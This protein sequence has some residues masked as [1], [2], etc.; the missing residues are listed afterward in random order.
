MLWHTIIR[1]VHFPQMD[2]ITCTQ[3]RLQQIDYSFAVF[4]SQESFNILEEKCS[5]THPC[6]GLGEA[7]NQTITL[8]TITSHPCRRKT[9]ARGA[10]NNYGRSG[11]ICI[12]MQIALLR[13]I[14][15][16]S[17]IRVKRSLIVV[18]RADRL[19]GRLLEPKRQPANPAE[20]V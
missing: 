2:T 17:G 15:N 9:L 16:V 19:K 18:Y 6:D 11:Q 5:R 14:S 7:G 3:Q 20:E 4:S 1:G 12:M 13:M 10:A 8:V